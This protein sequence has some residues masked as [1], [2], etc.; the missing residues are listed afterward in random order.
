MKL[1]ADSEPRRLR[2]MLGDALLLVWILAW[3]EIGKA[4]HDATMLLARPGEEITAA[5]NGLAE[6]LREASSVVGDA[7]IFGD[8]LQS[9][10][11]GAGDAADQIAG[12]GT[13]QVE[14][15]GTLASWLG[16]T[17][18]L[19]PVLVMLAI[20][21]PMRWRFA[22]QAGA[23]QRFVNAS[24]DL[25][26]FALRALASQPMHRL[27]KI[28]DDPAGAWRRGDTEVVRRLAVLELKEVG[29]KPPALKSP[30]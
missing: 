26:L 10:F 30:A 29:L 2:Q 22:R 7:P 23:G 3:I 4:V 1:Y 11:D 18:G 16:W 27:A 15:V 6:K 14:A 24:E 25:D 5:G 13:A 19:I 21:V 28:S 12:A 17:V 9:P 8:D 20:Y